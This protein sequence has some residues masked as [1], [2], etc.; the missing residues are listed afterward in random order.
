MGPGCARFVQDARHGA[1]QWPLL[2]LSWRGTGCDSVYSLA[3]VNRPRSTRE[4]RLV[5]ALLRGLSFFVRRA[6]TGSCP[7]GRDARPVAVGPDVG[8]VGDLPGRALPSESCICI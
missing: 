6:V 3:A 1:V 5:S 7:C 8:G 4:L 2:P